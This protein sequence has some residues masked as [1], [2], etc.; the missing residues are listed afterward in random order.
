MWS[1]EAAKAAVV[2]NGKDLPGNSDGDD[3]GGNN[4]E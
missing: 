4:V 3:D 1:W 2:S